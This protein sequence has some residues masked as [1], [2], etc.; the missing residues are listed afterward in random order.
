MKEQFSGIGISN[1]QMR[2]KRN[3][4]EEYGLHAF[5]NENGGVTFKMEIPVLH[6]GGKK[7]ENCNCR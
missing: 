5:L 1:I 7:R 2:I 4:G 3:F 6:L